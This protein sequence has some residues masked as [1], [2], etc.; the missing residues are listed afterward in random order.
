[1]RVVYRHLIP[2]DD[3]EHKI[4]TSARNRI[5]LVDSKEDERRAVHVWIEQEPKPDVSMTRTVRVFGTG[6][7]IPDGWEHLGSVVAYPFV[8]HLYEKR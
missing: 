8:W 7:E 4:V 3:D 5:V 1:M 2:I 6:H